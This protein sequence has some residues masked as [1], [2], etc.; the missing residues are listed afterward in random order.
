MLKLIRLLNG[1]REPVP[2]FYVTT[3]IAD[4]WIENVAQRIFP[5]EQVAQKPHTFSVFVVNP[6]LSE[7]CNCVN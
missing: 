6:N 5:Q 1:L 3:E 7:I 4:S 2:V